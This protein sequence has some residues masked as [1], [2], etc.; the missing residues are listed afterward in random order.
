VKAVARLAKHS[1]GVPGL[2]DSGVSTPMSRTVSPST[3]IVSP[4]TTRSTRP[5]R[6]RA[7]SPMTRGRPNPAAV[8]TARARTRRRPSD[9]TATLRHAAAVLQPPLH[10][11]YATVTSGDR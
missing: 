5:S 11:L 3:T 8:R 1:T 6:V 9:T 4:S 10:F 7:S 2:T